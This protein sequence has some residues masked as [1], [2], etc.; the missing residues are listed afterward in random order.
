MIGFKTAVLLGCSLQMGAQIAGADAEDQRAIYDFGVNLGTA[1]Q[2]QDD[3]LDSFGGED[4]GKRIG[5]DIL[6]GKKTYLFIKTL[7]MA[8]VEDRESL[9]KMYNDPLNAPDAPPADEVL[10][11]QRIDAVKTM[12]KKYKA[13][14]FLLE[15]IR[16]YTQKALD[17]IDQL[18][19]D[20]QR[21]HPLKEFSNALMKRK[22]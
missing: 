20:D 11:S 10:I 16:L 17:K 7:E 4:F 21:K 2:L 3:Y 13:D 8:N 19:I 12:F 9:L 22:V 6:E 1:F 18:T 14:E 15:E 5:G